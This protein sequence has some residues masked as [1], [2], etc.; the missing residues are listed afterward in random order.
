MGDNS[1]D[2]ETDTEKIDIEEREMYPEN[3][4]EVTEIYDYGISYDRQEKNIVLFNFPEFINVD[5]IVSV[6]IDGVE[7]LE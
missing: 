6:T 1:F 5:D 3:E 4:P 7:C 2:G